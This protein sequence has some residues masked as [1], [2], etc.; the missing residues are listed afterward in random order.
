M[1]ETAENVK[2][3]VV[4]AP[5]YLHDVQHQSIATLIAYELDKRLERSTLVYD[6]SDG[7]SDLLLLNID[8]SAIRV[9]RISVSE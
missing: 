5:A 9:A 8:N 6:L 4:T 3:A 7:T 2:H 1:K